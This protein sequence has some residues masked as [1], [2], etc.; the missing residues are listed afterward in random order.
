MLGKVTKWQMTE[1]ERLAYIAKHPI[2]PTKMPSEAVF[3]NLTDSN[4]NQPKKKSGEVN[5][6][7]SNGKS[8]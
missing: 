8:N 6:R 7:T 5:V 4:F 2:V 3:A 1:K